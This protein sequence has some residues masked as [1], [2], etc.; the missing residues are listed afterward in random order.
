MGVLSRVG[1]NGPECKV[2]LVPPNPCP[3]R[4]DVVKQGSQVNLV[5]MIVWEEELSGFVAELRQEIDSVD[6][7]L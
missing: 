6:S 1:A 4:D 3:G 5:D 2:S 7:P